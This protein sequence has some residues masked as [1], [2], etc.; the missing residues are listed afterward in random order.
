MY[1][2]SVEADAQTLGNKYNPNKSGRQRERMA[3]DRPQT[4]AAEQLLRR[5][6]QSTLGIS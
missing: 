3:A 2:I 1:V 4:S 6:F 5:L